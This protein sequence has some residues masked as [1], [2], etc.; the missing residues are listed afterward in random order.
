MVPMVT[1][2]VAARNEEANIEACLRS[3]EE[4][5][6][7]AARL[8][9]IAVDGDSSDRTRELAEAIVARHPGWRLLDNPR[10]IQAVAWNLG[11]QRASGDV[12]GIV[13]GH[14]E[15]AP[16]YVRQ[17]V[18]TLERTGAAMV[19]GPVTAL[20]DGPVSA[21]IGAAMASP[22]GVGGARH[23]YLTSEAQTDTVFMGVA[24]TETYR[25]FSFDEEM[26]RNQD[27]ELS[28]RLVDAGHA[29]VC[30]PAIRSR[31]RVRSSIGALARQ[32]W[33]YGY[34]KVAVLGRHPRRAKARHVLPALVVCGLAVIGPLSLV[35]GWARAMLL[36]GSLP[37]VAIDA[38]LAT[39]QA[40]EHGAASGLAMS[41]AFPTMHASYGAGFMRGL[42]DAWRRRRS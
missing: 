3:L 41:V 28:Y 6:Y 1:L 21:A 23:H 39:R 16:D 33:S 27:D 14:A 18:E 19:G 40:R 29:I 9:V 24:A 10:R 8:E 12:V 5:D 20:T 37:Y 15:L 26:V 11:I 30:N 2:V 4:Q 7:D 17:A 31:Y 25:A 38:I 13:S 42:W 35:S 34:W 36:A 22:F 32:Y